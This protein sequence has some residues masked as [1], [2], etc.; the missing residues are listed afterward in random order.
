MT[1]GRVLPLRSVKPA[2]NDDEDNRSG[3]KGCEWTEYESPPITR[4]AADKRGS[5]KDNEHKGTACPCESRQPGCDDFSHRLMNL[6]KILCE[7]S[8]E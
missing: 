3:D 8:N 4:F 2:K 5:D 7:A 1:A 6:S